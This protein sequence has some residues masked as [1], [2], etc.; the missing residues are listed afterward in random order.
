L[1]A[2]PPFYE[3]IIVAGL[4]YSFSMSGQKMTAR[5]Q[6]KIIR[7]GMRVKKIQIPLSEEERA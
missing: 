3:W 1:C 6:R 4:L 2:P 7:L 5:I